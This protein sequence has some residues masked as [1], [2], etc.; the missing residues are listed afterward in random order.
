MSNGAHIEGNQP[1]RRRIAAQ[2]WSVSTASAT[3][4]PARACASSNAHFPNCRFPARSCPSPDGNKGNLLARIGP[5]AEGGVILSGHT[6]CRAGRRT[7]LGQRA[8]HPHPARR[9][10]LRARHVGYE[11]SFIAVCLAMA[12]EFRKLK[13][14]KPVYFAFSYDEE[15]GCLGAPHLL[16]P[17]RSVDSQARLSPSSAKP[18]M[19]QVVTAHKGV[20][21]VETTFARPRM[22]FQ[23]AALR[24]QYG[25]LPP[26]GLACIS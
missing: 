26:A 20:L 17:Y 6:D 25:A 15:I 14:A 3:S 22:A 5:E 9:K 7:V 18:T 12:P 4:Q 24:R 21:F 1:P 23:P 2:R 13:F 11:T 16:A 8:L 19:M 10:I